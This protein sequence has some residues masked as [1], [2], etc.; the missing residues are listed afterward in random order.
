MQ[1][2][3]TEDMVFDLERIRYQFDENR[4][5]FIIVTHASNVCGLIAP[6]KDIFGIG[7]KYGAVT[8]V[9]MAQTAGLLD[10][11]LSLD[12]YDF[13]V[14]E[15]HKTLYGPFGVAGFIKTK[16]FSLSQIFAGGTGSDSLNLDMP[17]T[18]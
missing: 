7:K 12:I 16:E 5:D 9:D 6:V 3:V 2:A 13:A 1:L 8:L 10:S 4:P 14:F 15:G 11:D 17:R 18:F